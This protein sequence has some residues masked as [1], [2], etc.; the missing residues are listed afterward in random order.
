ME[1]YLAW[2]L[3]G[4]RA[5]GLPIANWQWP[6][7]KST[8]REWLSANRQSAIVIPNPFAVYQA[9]DKPG[10]ESII[11]VDD[12]HIGSAELSMPSSAATPPNDAP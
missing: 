7:L 3:R 4:K 10:A 9:G 2:C 12:R 11:D 6:I 5:M 8:K 1:V